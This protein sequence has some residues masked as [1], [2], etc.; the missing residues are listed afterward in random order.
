[1]GLLDAVTRHVGAGRG[2]VVSIVGEA[3]IGKSRLVDEIVAEFTASTP[4]VAVFDGACAPYGEANVWWPIGSAI[5]GRFGIRSGATADDVR[6]S[7]LAKLATIPGLHVESPEVRRELE[8]LLYVLGHPSEL[9][10]LDPVGARDAL[11][12]AVITMLRRRSAVGPVVLWIDDLQWSH[13]PLRDLLE[14]IA[15]SL[16][17]CPLLV[18]TAHRPGHDLEWPPAVERAFTV[19]LPLGPL[20]QHESAVLV[21]EIVGPASTPDLVQR[22]YER[23][24]GNP[25]FLSELALLATADGGDGGE[26]PGSLRA[27]ISARL[28]ELTPSCRAIIDNAAVLGTESFVNALEEFA[29]AMGQ[30]FDRPIST[31]WS[32]PDCSR[33]TARG[34]GSAATSCARWRTRRSP[35]RPAPS[36]T[37]GTATVMA[38]HP[39]SPI[40]AGAHHAATAA[41]LL[42]ELGHGPRRAARHR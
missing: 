14:V 31:S 5:A 22:L 20:D 11:V 4:Q 26:L 30:R 15:R 13:G 1:V 42:A 41:E 27:L 39:K 36:A 19:Q 21:G 2:A 12:D 23:S 16:A 9:D 32:S 17:D 18:I 7:A 25:L 34:G 37:P 10:L 24:G 3:G 40:E 29:Q 35:S 33:S 6:T 8:A 38:A 28:D